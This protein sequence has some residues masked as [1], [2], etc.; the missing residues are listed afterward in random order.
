VEMYLPTGVAA[1]SSGNIYFADSNN[2]RVRELSGSTVNTVAGNGLLSRSGDGGAA[3]S[4]QLYAPRGVALDSSGNL[5]IAD[6][7]N[8]QIRKVT[9]AGVISTFAGTG[10]AGSSGDG[11]AATAAQ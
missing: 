5:Y 11:G 10:T 1:D 9:A 2:N 4:A 7:A 8:N 3:T 6:T